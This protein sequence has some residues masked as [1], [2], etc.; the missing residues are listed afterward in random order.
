M[1]APQNPADLA[2]ARLTDVAEATGRLLRTLAA[3]EPAAVAGPSALPGWTRG[4]VL[5]HVARNA[6]S[7]VNLLDGARTGTD[8]PQYASDEA[9]DLGIE[10][11]AP[12]PLDVQADDVR[13]SH[14]G[15]AAAAALLPAEAWAASVR[16]RSGYLFPAHD[17][18]WKRLMELEY[19]HVDLAAGYSPADWPE[20]FATAEFRRLA[21]RLAG[22]DAA[23]G[24]GASGD[25]P[26]ALPAALLVAG[27]T[28]DRARIGSADGEARLSVEGPVRTL[29]AWLSGRS[30]GDG[31]LVR[32]D[33][34]PLADGRA[35]LPPL[36]PLG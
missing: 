17:I 23:A 8:V 26:T 36:P 25:L 21:A 20:P 31:L 33:G 4:H 7:L 14:A 19:H 16:H 2:A 22:A 12:R 9:R 32:E 18:P 13:D 6:D 28:G 35:A 15:F 34:V 10:Q 11:G 3:L 24:A 27:D 5:A 30:D 1:T 29:T